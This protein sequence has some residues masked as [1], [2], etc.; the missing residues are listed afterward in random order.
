MSDTKNTGVQTDI[1][2]FLNDEGLNILVTCE[3]KYPVDEN[4]VGLTGKV[5]TELVG[6]SDRVLES[7]SWGIRH[8]TDPKM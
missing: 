7:V 4:G 6:L 8:S 1:K 5:Q 3:G 2:K